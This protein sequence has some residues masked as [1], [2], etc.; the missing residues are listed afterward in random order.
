MGSKGLKNPVNSKK[1][2]VFF[3]PNFGHPQN[4]VSVFAVRNCRFPFGMIPKVGNL[5]FTY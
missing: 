4:P 3:A 2:S 1:K 5:F